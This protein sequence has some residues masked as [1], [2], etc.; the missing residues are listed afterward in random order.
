MRDGPR[1]A[2]RGDRKELGGLPPL[3]EISFILNNSKRAQP[4]F[5]ISEQSVK[6]AVLGQ[7]LE[8]FTCL[9][10]K[11]AVIRYNNSRTTSWLQDLHNVLNEVQL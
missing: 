1:S 2:V 7:N 4:L 8:N 6:I 5:L 11:Q 3:H 9:I 10:S